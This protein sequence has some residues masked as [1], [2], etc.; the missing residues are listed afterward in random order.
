MHVKQHQLHE[1]AF[2]KG[3][4]SSFAFGLGS[5]KDGDLSEFGASRTSSLSVSVD[6][7]LIVTVQERERDRMRLGQKD[8]LHGEKEIRKE[9]SDLSY[10]H[11][12]RKVILFTI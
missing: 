2:Y 12:I 9:S 1:T 6:I 3:S 8:C 10:L 11:N 5:P 7:P 4:S